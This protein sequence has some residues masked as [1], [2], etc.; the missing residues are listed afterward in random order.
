MATVQHNLAKKDLGDFSTLLEAT[1]HGAKLLEL[2]LTTTKAVQPQ[3]A[4]PGLNPEE[5]RLDFTTVKPKARDLVGQTNS[6]VNM[7]TKLEGAKLL[8]V[9]KLPMVLLTEANLRHNTVDGQSIPPRVPGH[10]DTRTHP[11]RAAE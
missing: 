6:R 9:A 3:T 1:S 5:F 10:E 8:D 7:I 4:K 11:K 2:C